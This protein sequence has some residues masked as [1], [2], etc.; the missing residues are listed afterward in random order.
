MTTHKNN[1]V[2]SPFSNNE[3]V[4][5]M[6]NSNFDFG[7]MIA[8]D[9]YEMPYSSWLTDE[10]QTFPQSNFNGDQYT[11]SGLDST[12]EPTVV[13]CNDDDDIGECNRPLQPLILTDCDKVFTP[14]SPRPK[15]KRTEPTVSVSNS[16][17]NSSQDNL[18]ELVSEMRTYIHQIHHF[19]KLSVDMVSSLEKQLRLL[20]K[21]KTS[22]AKA[23]KQKIQN[24]ER[25]RLLAL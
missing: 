13:D 11:F 7:N 25:G 10:E 14:D 22:K 15:R 3:D 23:F 6:L 4:D 21:P 19:Q 2:I 18:E 17:T 1:D 8:V 16:D 5:K 12:E 24:Q 20:R 9:S